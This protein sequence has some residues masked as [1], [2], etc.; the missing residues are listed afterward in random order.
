MNVLVTGGCGFVGA[1]LI[2]HLLAA[3]PEARVVN[4]DALT[5]AG[6][7]ARLA[8]VEREAG[9]TGRYVFVRGDVTDA[10]LV[11]ATLRAHA[12]DHVIHAAAETHVD[13]SIQDPQVFARTNLLGTSVVLEAARAAA[14][15]RLLFVST[16]EVY[17]PATT[18]RSVET[19]PFVP[20]SPYAA[21][22]AG[23]ELLVLAHHRTFGLPVIVARPCNTY[24]PWQ[25][26][27]KLIPLMIT[28]A[29]ADQPLPVYGDGAQVRE[30]L[31]VED[32]AA[33]LRLLLER[34]A[35]GRAYNVGSGDERPNLEVV[36]RILARL[37][38]PEALLRHVADRPGHDRRYALD[39]TRLR[40][41]L[42]WTPEISF[43]AGLDATVDWT[44]AHAAWHG[45]METEATRAMAARIYGERAP[46]GTP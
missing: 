31:H 5:Y 26:P 37:G 27:E 36:R 46:G 16:D 23:A 34:G 45:S 1:A 21:S 32:H 9:P 38:K 2:R 4:L 39:C 6:S 33:A 3:R 22:K 42:G 18:G 10:A 15:R 7:P 44:V 8:D 24:G 35:P 41:E 14:V 19:A 20:T 30:W 25:L 13:R 43:D 11:A 12:V 29:A 40:D 28:R 17:G